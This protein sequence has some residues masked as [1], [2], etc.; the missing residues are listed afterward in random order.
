MALVQSLVRELRSH[1]PEHKQKRREA[2][3]KTRLL[4]SKHSKS[5]QVLSSPS[6][7]TGPH[8]LSKIRNQESLCCFTLLWKTASH[9]HI[10]SPLPLQGPEHWNWVAGTE[11]TILSG[12]TSHEGT[13]PVTRSAGISILSSVYPLALGIASPIARLGF[14][15][16]FKRWS[17]I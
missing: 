4:V 17:Q 6:N 2:V 11:D 1:K 7:E 10:M 12:T 9:L 5:R 14:K 8:K 13:L 15:K 3:Q 16:G